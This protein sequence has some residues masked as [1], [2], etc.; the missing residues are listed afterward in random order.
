MILSDI[1]SRLKQNTGDLHEIIPVS[2]NMQE[3]LHN[4]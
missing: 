4:M 2:F 3:I 1:L